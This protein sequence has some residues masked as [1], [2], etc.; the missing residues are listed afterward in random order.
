MSIWT[1]LFLIC[2]ILAAA[3]GIVALVIGE[4]R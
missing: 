2:G 3:L 1:G 4:E